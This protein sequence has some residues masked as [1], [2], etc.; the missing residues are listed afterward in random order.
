MITNS[1]RIIDGTEGPAK[2]DVEARKALAEFR[3]RAYRKYPSREIARRLGADY[4]GIGDVYYRSKP[5]D[6]PEAVAFYK[7]AAECYGKVCR[8][9]LS[10][11]DNWDL[12]VVLSKLGWS[13]FAQES[14]DLANA[15][16]CFRQECRLF[17]KICCPGSSGDLKGYA[18]SW[19]ELSLAYEAAGSHRQ[20]FEASTER[21]RLLEL[22]YEKYPSASAR[23]D[24]V[25]A[26]EAHVGLIEKYGE[27]AMRAAIPKYRRRI[28]ELRQDA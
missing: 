13:Y 8:D 3:L 17:E 15:I 16:D 18:H 9:N 7:K 26:I 20:M 1:G 21:I 12:I 25:S 22:R 10:N 2:V 23:D 24:C 11:G 14:A 19:Y 28:N 27:R 5:A 4:S 6:Y